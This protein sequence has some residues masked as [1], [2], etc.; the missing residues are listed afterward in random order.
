MGPGNPSRLPNTAVLFVSLS[1][2]SLDG[3]AGEALT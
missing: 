2:Q 3:A 1:S